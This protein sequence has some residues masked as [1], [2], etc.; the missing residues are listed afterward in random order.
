MPFILS[1]FIGRILLAF[2]R[3]TPFSLKRLCFSSVV[4]ISSFGYRVHW[5][6]KNNKKGESR[7]FQFFFFLSNWVGVIAILDQSD[8]HNRV[9]VTHPLHSLLRCLPH[10]VYIFISHPPLSS[11]QCWGKFKGL[12]NGDIPISLSGSHSTAYWEPSV[13]GS[14]HL[15]PASPRSH[16]YPVLSPFFPL[17]YDLF[18]SRDLIHLTFVFHSSSLINV[19]WFYV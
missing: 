6:Y 5:C 19:D 8:Y 7:G 18:E 3:I 15:P 9:Q 2:L 14:K 4:N 12:C 13:L 11:S 16:L 1:L 17:D 10:F